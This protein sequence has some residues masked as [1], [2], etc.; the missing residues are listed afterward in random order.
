M[1][2]EYILRDYDIE[3]LDANNNW[4]AIAS[5]TDN[6]S[7]HRTHTISTITTTSLRVVAK[8]GS[9]LQ[10]QHAR[11]NEIVVFGT[12]PLIRALDILSR[13]SI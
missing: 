7:I 10:P 9:V 11:I 2:E 6:T 12:A 4:I 13:G 3:Y 5:V 1:T 8:K